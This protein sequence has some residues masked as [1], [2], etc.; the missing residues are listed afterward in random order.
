[1][2][3]NIKNFPTRDI[4]TVTT[5][6]LLAKGDGLHDNGINNLYRLLEWMTGEPPF[7]HQLPR[8][9]KECKPWLL[10]WFPELGGVDDELPRLDWLLGGGNGRGAAVD[11][12]LATLELPESYDVPQIPRDDHTYIDP[13]KEAEDMFGKDR[14]IVVS[15]GE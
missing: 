1:M 3:V 11:D 15:P 4:L 13:V 8:F 5:G 2:N 9:A 14:V 12:W 6:R 7:N 10:R